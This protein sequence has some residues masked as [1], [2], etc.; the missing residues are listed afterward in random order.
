MIQAIV[1]PKDQKVKSQLDELFKSKVFDNANTRIPKRNCIELKATNLTTNDSSPTNISIS[2]PKMDLFGELS[3][4]CITQMATK[5]GKN[6]WKLRKAAMDEVNQALE[7]SNGLVSSEDKHLSQVAS[8]IKALRE[9]LDDSQSNL[10]PQAANLIGKVLGSLDAIAQGKLA[11]LAFYQ[12]L[13]PALTDNRKP[14][15]ETCIVALKQATDKLAI[16][17]G[18]K[19]PAA[20]EALL[21]PVSTLLKETQYKVWYI[22]S[23]NTNTFQSFLIDAIFHFKAVGTPEVL[24]FMTEC[25]EHFPKHKDLKSAK[26]RDLEGEFAK[27]CLFCLTSSKSETRSAVENLIRE[28]LSFD[29]ISRASIEKAFKTLPQ[30]EQRSISNTLRTFFSDCNE[31]SNIPLST[32]IASKSKYNRERNGVDKNRTSIGGRGRST[33]SRNNSTNN[34]LVSSVSRINTK[35]IPMNVQTEDLSLIFPLLKRTKPF[36]KSDNWPDFPEEPSNQSLLMVLNKAW[37]SC[38]TPFAVSELFPQEGIQKQDDAMAGIK[39]LSSSLTM[40]GRNGPNYLVLDHIDMISKWVAFSLCTRENT[41]G[42]QCLLKFLRDFLSF[43]KSCNYRFNDSEAGVLFPLLLEKASLAKVIRYHPFCYIIL[44][45]TLEN[46]EIG[47]ISL[48]LW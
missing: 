37:S 5:E 14:M 30:A 7:K 21:L 10:K 38:L 48:G 6:A 15:R 42:L 22:V 32:S 46:I 34:S 25:A 8:V 44:Y 27:Q 16:E 12:L 26:S 35:E 40:E 1:K 24:A 28:C 11:K 9:R 29:V 31:N 43:L 41:V 4:D 45:L 23:V 19:N 3:S 39:V 33:S 17:G 47:T 2:I 20:V 36:T 18:G 13:S